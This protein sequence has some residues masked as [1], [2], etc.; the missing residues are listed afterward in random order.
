M[1]MVPANVKEELFTFAIELC[2][3]QKELGAWVSDIPTLQ[4][5]VI[6][7]QVIQ[8]LLNFRGELF[9]EVICNSLDWLE[10]KDV[11]T[12]EYC[13]WRLLPLILAK[14]KPDVIDDASKQVQERVK[15][16]I[17]H[18]E[19]SP[20][21]EFYIE[22][23][24][25]LKKDSAEKDSIINKWKEL[26][27][28]RFHDIINLKEDKLAYLLYDLATIWKEMPSEL[29]ISMLSIIEQKSSC[30]IGKR[31]WSSLVSSAYTVSNLLKVVRICK[32]EKITTIGMQLVSEGTNYLI[33][34][35]LN[36][37]F[38]SEPQS[39]GP[40]ENTIYAKLIVAR[41]LS[42]EADFEDPRWREDIWAYRVNKNCNIN[43]DKMKG[44]KVKLQLPKRVTL[45]WVY[46]NVPLT[47]WLT[48]AGII[49]AIFSG[50]IYVG[51]IDIVR[52]II[53]GREQPLLTN[54]YPK[55]NNLKVHIKQL[56]DAHNQ[57]IND[58]TENFIKEEQAA[59]QRLHSLDRNPHLEA[60]NHLKE[61]LRKENEDFLKAITELISLENNK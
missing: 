29:I 60:A 53:S 61:L 32:Q 47:T 18:H 20:I 54:Q 45:S 7:P 41:C 12:N 10:R 37:D 33:S 11:A 38:K 46:Q 56:S 24:F 35:W 23:M 4:S 13:H 58:I 26:L 43:N 14:A 40:F 1:S 22:C 5:C 27:E 48:I 44:H 17:K 42:D 6:T 34:N 51:Q 16:N 57:R 52:S 2:K 3:D 30:N 39:G 31:K 49:G 28:K 50:G 55:Y 15:N 21:D 36:K 19:N 25:L 8:F 59:A 9:Q